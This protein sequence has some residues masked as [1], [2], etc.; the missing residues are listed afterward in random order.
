LLLIDDNDQL[1]AEP[2]DGETILAEA[3]GAAGLEAVDHALRSATQP[4][5]LK[6]ARVVID[7]IKAGGHGADEARVHLYARRVIALVDAGALEAQGNL[8]RPRFSE[9][10]LPIVRSS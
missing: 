9:I 1:P 5:W 2:S 8:R 7:A 10:R 3:V 4:R 6:V